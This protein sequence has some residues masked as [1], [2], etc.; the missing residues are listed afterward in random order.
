MCK[1]AFLRSDQAGEEG[2]RG[3][4]C[5]YNERREV[6]SVYYSECKGSG[7]VTYF[8]TSMSQSLSSRSLVSYQKGEWVE[9]RN[10]S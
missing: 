4:P 5:F 6:G 9:T 7:S 2:R 3:R 1:R 8:L 10:R